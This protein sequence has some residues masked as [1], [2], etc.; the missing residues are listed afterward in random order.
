MRSRVTLAFATGA[1]VVSA[2]L[3]GATYGLAHHYLLAQRLS[4]A[5][6][7]TFANARL[8]KQDLT[9][10]ATDVAAVLSS[11]TP[12]QGTRSLLYRNG[13][14]F[15][16]SVSVGHAA[17]P[18]PLVDT[19]L[20]GAPARQR[21]SLPGGPAVAV[22][23]PLPSVGADYFEVHSLDELARTL[24]LLA[25]VL[26]VGAVAT[27]LGGVA[28]GRWASRRLVRPLPEVAEVAAAISH[29]QVG[30]RLPIA[31]DSDL[32]P[33]VASFNEM[34]DALQARIDRDTRF[35]SDV[36]HELRS[37]LTTVQTS[38]ELLELFRGSL[39]PDGQRALELVS[40]EMGRF[41][42]M[43]QDLLEISR[44]DAGAASLDLEEVDL[45][46][47]VVNTVAAHTGGT[48]PVEVEPGAVGVTVRGD[49]RRLQ[50]VIVNLL[51]NARVH[52]GGA[53]L[54]T[55]ARAGNRA[56]AIV[57]DAG[58]GV[59]IDERGRIFERFY[60]GAVSGR[61]SE[62]SGLG[63]S[64]TA[65]HVKAH[66]GQVSVLDRPGGGARFVVELPVQPG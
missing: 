15:S 17:L 23:I 38:V 53:V 56:R 49:R 27:T 24:D 64:L 13:R 18:T 6:N 66:N 52:A 11:L 34:V 4:S 42:T 54:V 43:V 59:P 22:G 51:D 32:D 2:V 62:G 21:I 61:R 57:D 35:A 40:V 33:L 46:E 55:V 29:G 14:W 8:L 37:P 28:A 39:P 19:V 12:A 58:P 5:V 44:M 36:S 60:R 31:H 50:R 41:S 7:Q 47:L 20:R 25:I 3:A 30:Q 48:V 26:G 1:A 63:L 16:T 10:P 65:E 45:D 9:P